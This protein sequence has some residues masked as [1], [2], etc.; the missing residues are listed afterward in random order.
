MVA[1]D[2]RRLMNLSIEGGARRRGQPVRR[3]GGVI[4]TSW[5]LPFLAFGN[6]AAANDAG[7]DAITAETIRHH[8]AILAS[9]AYTGRFPGTAGEDSTLAYLER[10]LRSL[11]LEP[12]VNGSYRQ[13]VPLVRRTV[14]PTSEFRGSRDAMMR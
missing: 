12:I 4:S 5:L 3:A 6:A 14:L 10:Q 2:Q 8:V 11:G 1:T 7:L 13:R 9:D